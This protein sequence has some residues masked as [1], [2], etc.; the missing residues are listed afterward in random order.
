M[1]IDG[2]RDEISHI[3]SKAENCSKTR[4]VLGE[5]SQ[6]AA[7]AEYVTSA[8]IL[9]GSTCRRSDPTDAAG[10]SKPCRHGN[11]FRHTVGSCPL[12]QYGAPPIVIDSTV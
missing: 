1:I 2:I 10:D 6:G 9:A 11:A 5:Y 3:E 4:E 8:A 7:V 12:R